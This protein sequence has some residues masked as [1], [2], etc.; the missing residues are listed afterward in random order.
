MRKYWGGEMVHPS[1]FTELAELIWVNYCRGKLQQTKAIVQVSM[2]SRKKQESRKGTKKNRPHTN[3]CNLFAVTVNETFPY[4]NKIYNESCQLC[5]AICCHFHPVL[6]TQPQKCAEYLKC[7][8]SIIHHGHLAKNART[9][10]C[11]DG[12]L[13]TLCTVLLRAHLH[14]TKN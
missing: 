4:K 10:K 2:T 14:M 8:N 13:A 5:Y 7:L 11:F 12:W 6:W 1:W 3:S 9:F